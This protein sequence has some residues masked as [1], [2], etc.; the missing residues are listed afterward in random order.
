MTFRPSDDVLEEMADNNWQSGASTNQYYNYNNAWDQW[1]WQH[2]FHNSDNAENNWTSINEDVATIEFDIPTEEVKAPDLS[3]LL[4]NS[5]GND[6]NFDDIE[7]IQVNNEGADEAQSINENSVNRQINVEKDVSANDVEVQ[8]EIS[9][10]MEEGVT[11]LWKLSDQERAEIVSKLDWS[12]HSNLDLLVD[13]EWFSVIE[14]YKKIHRIFF[15]WWIFIL[16]SLIGATVWAMLQV[17]VDAWEGLNIVKDSSIQVKN[18][19]LEET[20]VTMLSELE[21][22]GV[23]AII[24]YGTVKVDWTSFQSRSNLVSYKWL[25]LPQVASIDTESNNIFSVEDFNNQKVSREDIE[26][27][28]K[29]LI[30][31]SVIYRKTANL[32]SPKDNKW[33]WQEFQWWLIDWFSLWCLWTSKPTDFV[34]NKFLDIFNTYGKYFN[35]SRYDTDILSLMKTLKRHHYSV[36]PICNMIKEY[37][38][39]SWYSSSVLSAAMENCGDEQYE[40]YKKMINFIEVENSLSQPELPSK[41]FDDPDLNAYKLISAQQTVYKY[42]NWT[43]TFNKNYV[44]SYLTYVQALINKDKWSNRYLAPMYKDLLYVF[45]MDELYQKLLERS[46]LTS[47]L[48][49][50]IDQINNGNTLFQYESLLLQLTT[51]NIIKSNWSFASWGTQRERSLEDVFSQYYAMTDRLK[52]R[53][54][55]KISDTEARVLT[56]IYTDTILWVTEW[57]TLK[58]TVEL[59]RRDNVLY[60]D[61]IRIANQPTLTDILNMYAWNESVT[62]YAMLAYIDEQITFWYEIPEED[63]EDKWDLCEE[64]AKDENVSVYNC[65][66][67]WISLYKWNIEYNFKLSEWRLESFTISDS[68]LE[69]MIKEMLN[70]VM[71]TRDNTPTIIKSIVDFEIETTTEDNIEKKVQ[72]VD[73]FR[74]HFKTIPNVYD[75]EWETDVF[76]VE[77]LLWDFDIQAHYNV[78]THLLTRISYVACDKILEIKKLSIEISAD[79]EQQ[80]T[81]ILN[82][83]KVF[84]NQANQ[85]AYRK[86]LKMCEEED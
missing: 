83:P 58:A 86:Y 19:R 59:S 4:K 21:D 60:V 32:L 84:F 15:K 11:I 70:S 34:C 1:D 3:E 10:E 81:E 44:V 36:E 63:S 38:W 28:I 27:T 25:I 71:I 18:Q 43:S 24:P 67:S 80:L 41:V 49:M 42:L 55:S 46:E 17:K 47:D 22:E 77:F 53:K 72:V 51:Q 79:N 31:S 20:P 7:K 14:K 12:I 35:L 68:D 78:E 76:L 73:Q 39:R 82:N 61:N 26:N 57:E 8:W 29:S 13:E 23:K 56:E 85:A 50:Q 74:I 64:I 52:I 65:D 62:F 45:N 2:F 5:W 6:I 48:K 75:I 33:Q 40:Y 30:T 69:E 54:F 16:I 37:T 9:S 66:D